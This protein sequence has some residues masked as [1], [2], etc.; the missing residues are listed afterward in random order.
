LE[1][2]T[3]PGQAPNTL[4][5]FD[6]RSVGSDEILG[7]WPIKFY[8][9]D[10]LKNQVAAQVVERVMRWQASSSSSTA[11]EDIQ[12][13][14]ENFGQA[15]TNKSAN[16][17]WRLSRAFIEDVFMNGGSRAKG[18]VGNTKSAASARGWGT[19]EGLVTDGAAAEFCDGIADWWPDVGLMFFYVCFYF[20]PTLDFAGLDQA[21]RIPRDGA[22][23]QGPDRLPHV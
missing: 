22:V 16:I 17:P 2:V 1:E 15:N 8:D 7:S 4:I 21:R 14:K 11:E 19:A 5:K 3:G 12:F 20:L 13:E 23:Q 18:S 6:V 9:S 10:P